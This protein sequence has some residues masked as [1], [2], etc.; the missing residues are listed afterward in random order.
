VAHKYRA[1]RV[2]RRLTCAL[3]HG[4]KHYNGIVLDLS[5]TGLFVQTSA[6]PGP[7]DA[8]ELELQ[9]PDGRG[10]LVLQGVA[11]RRRTV[12][13]QMRSV[14]HGGVGVR[15]TAAPETYFNL[16]AEL[17]RAEVGRAEPEKESAPP[18]PPPKPAAKPPRE[19]TALERR[20][21]ELALRRVRGGAAAPDPLRRY[22]VKVAQAARSRIL[23]VEAR[24]DADAQRIALQEAGE[25]WRVIECRAL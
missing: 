2:K 7:G 6:S 25:G 21:R 14:A 11:A 24:G 13:L 16:V 8:L 22:R 20:A 12:P 3:R 10:A 4:G 9:P 23:E 19:P 18:E 1:P 15:L 5:A 17:L